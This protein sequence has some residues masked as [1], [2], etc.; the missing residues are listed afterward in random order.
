MGLKDSGRI[1]VGVRFW[2]NLAKELGLHCN[3][4]DM[5][6]ACQFYWPSFLG[7]VITKYPKRISTCEYKLQV[8]SQ[9]VL[10]IAFLF[11]LSLVWSVK[12]LDCTI[13]CHLLPIWKLIWL[14][15]IKIEPNAVINMI[16]KHT[17]TI[18][19]KCKYKDTI[20]LARSTLVNVFHRDPIA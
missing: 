19:S 2:E 20:Y 18:C 9:P 6:F 1:W 11:S 13:F 5:L 12:S 8:T 10:F 17:I 7:T 14:A 15:N 4:R 16:G 3:H